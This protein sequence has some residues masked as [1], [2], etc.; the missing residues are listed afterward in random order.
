MDAA[1][2]E[3]LRIGA[4]VLEG[5]A[6]ALTALGNILSSFPCS[7]RIGKLLVFGV[8]LGCL[9]AVSAVAACASTRSPF[10]SASDDD[11]A[12]RVERTKHM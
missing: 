11:M 12:R 8:L 9:S 10:M 3:L 2:A 4:L 5:E 1:Y 7:P 6:L